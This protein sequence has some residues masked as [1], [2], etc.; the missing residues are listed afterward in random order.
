MIKLLTC[1]VNVE[2]CCTDSEEGGSQGPR[3]TKFRGDMSMSQQSRAEPK[4]GLAF[5]F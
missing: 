4:Y 5:F 2:M 1:G 3:A